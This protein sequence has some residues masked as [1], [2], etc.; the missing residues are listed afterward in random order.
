MENQEIIIELKRL[1]KNAK[2]AIDWFYREKYTEDE[3]NSL[4]DSDC[5]DS[6]P[7]EISQEIFS[8]I[9]KLN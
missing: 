6:T 1:T 5:N 2:I 9:E 7:E 8:L 3:Y 4:I